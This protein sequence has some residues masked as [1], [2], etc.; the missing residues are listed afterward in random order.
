MSVFNKLCDPHLPQEQCAGYLRYAS[1]LATG[2]MARRCGVF[3]CFHVKCG[4]LV[5]AWLVVSW[6]VF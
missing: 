5:F 3:S 6:H 4:F 2:I 1:D